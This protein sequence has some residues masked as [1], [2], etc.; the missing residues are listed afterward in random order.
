MGII[1]FLLSVLASVT[2]SVLI[3]VG[4]DSQ[5]KPKLRFAVGISHSLPENDP[6]G[7]PA[8]KWIRVE[9]SNVNRPRWLSLLYNR[10]AAVMC[11]AWITFYHVQPSPDY[12]C[13]YNR[14]MAGRW[15]SSPPPKIQIVET[16]EGP[17]TV[18]SYV[19][20]S[21]DIPPGDGELLDVAVRFRDEEECYGYNNESHG[22]PDDWKNPV[23]RLEKGT[24]LVK[25]RVR[26]GGNDFC[27][28]FRIVN[29]VQ[30]DDFRI[31]K[32]SDKMVHDL[33][34]PTHST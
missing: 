14:E 24:Y 29:D 1:E 23:W 22:R 27:G 8:A 31:E 33:A 34:A 7:R 10:E 9:V 3:I 15:T 25:A 6:A 11:E 5:K 18:R 17:A 19:T 13:V 26:T 21:I 28:V 32:V 30:Y 12:R 4:I 2:A 16:P 20:K